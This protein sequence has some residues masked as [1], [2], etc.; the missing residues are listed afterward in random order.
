MGSKNYIQIVEEATVVAHNTSAFNTVEFPCLGFQG[1]LV[2]YDLT[3][4]YTGGSSPGLLFKLQTDTTGRGN[5]VDISTLVATTNGYTANAV[6]DPTITSTSKVYRFYPDSGV[7][8]TR[9]RINVS[10]TGSPTDETAT[11]N[12]ITVVSPTYA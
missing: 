7:T 9:M 8:G 5:W 12:S 6:A 3:V 4:A 2:T 11:I 1:L 10:V